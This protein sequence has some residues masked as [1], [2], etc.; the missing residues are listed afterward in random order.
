M[1]SSAFSHTSLR[2][3]HSGLAHRLLIKDASLEAED[4]CWVSRAGRAALKPSA[5]VQNIS[6]ESKPLNEGNPS[7]HT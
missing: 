7:A 6:R 3:A 4:G 1:P 2:P 5:L